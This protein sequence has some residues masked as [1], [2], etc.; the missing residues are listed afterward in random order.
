VALAAV[1]YF[2]VRGLTESVSRKESLSGK[3]KTFTL[4][5][6]PDIYSLLESE[7]PLSEK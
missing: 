5:L 7:I 2:L 3:G 6:D 4:L 1:N